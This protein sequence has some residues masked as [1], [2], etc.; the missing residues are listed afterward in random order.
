[1]PIFDR[2]YPRLGEIMEPDRNSFGVLRVAMA[3]LVL[4]S[5]SYLFHTGSS[6]GEPLTAWTGWS[7]GEHAVQVFFLLSGLLVAQSFDRSKGLVDFVLA[8]TLRIFPGLIVCVLLTALGLGAAMTTLPPSE[9]FSSAGLPAYIAKTVSLATGSAPLPGVFETVPLA[10]R[11][12]TS[13]WTLKYEVICYAGLAAAGLVGL[14]RSGWKG[15]A[16]LSLAIAGLA[17]F[18]TP[19]VLADNYT[20]KDNI[21]Y[22]ALFFAPGVLAYLV[23]ERLMISGLAVIPLLALFL[24][25]RGTQLTEIATALFL[26]YTALW[27]ASKSF[28]PLTRLTNR[29]DLSFGIYIYA[30]PIQ[31]A[32]INGVPGISPVGIAATAAVFAVPLALLSW[33]FVERP[34]MGLRAKLRNALTRITSPRQTTVGWQ[35]PPLLRGEGR[36]PFPHRHPRAAGGTPADPAAGTQASFR[37][38]RSLGPHGW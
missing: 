18:I 5:H 38:T 1:M 35:S 9:Y 37:C 17:V 23:R 11:V 3:S 4:V 7:L 33:V 27:A 34:A 2:A 31:Q 8:R 19:P 36:A 10:E 21:R 12:N 30:G 22:F 28:G 32:L 24:A 25:A 29:L 6:A 16:L 20:F 13:L 26:G 15:A 14:F